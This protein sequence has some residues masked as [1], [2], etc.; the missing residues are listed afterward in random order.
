M[1]RQQILYNYKE[2]FKHSGLGS[3]EIG[4]SR[5]GPHGLGVIPALRLKYRYYHL[6]YCIIVLQLYLI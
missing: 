6:S 3:Y 4:R 2:E 5:P 1:L